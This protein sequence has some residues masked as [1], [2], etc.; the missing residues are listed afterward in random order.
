MEIIVLLLICFC[1][2]AS[3]SSKTHS[4]NSLFNKNF[5]DNLKTENDLK[6]FQ[7]LIILQRN[8]ECLNREHFD[9]DELKTHQKNTNSNIADLNEIVRFNFECF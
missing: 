5:I 4:D 7:R 2:L 6:D 9:L 1:G 3:T 8:Y